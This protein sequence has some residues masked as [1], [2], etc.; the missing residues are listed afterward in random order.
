MMKKPFRWLCCTLAVA[1]F[2]YSSY[3]LVTDALAQAPT[4]T[5]LLT[6]GLFLVAIFMVLGR[7]S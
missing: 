2:A 5:I 6:A 4:A 7:S 3:L 1:A